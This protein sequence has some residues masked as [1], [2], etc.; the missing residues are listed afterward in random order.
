MEKFGTISEA[1]IDS[2]SKFAKQASDFLP[3]IVM[4]LVILIVGWLLAKLVSAGLRRGLK[5]IKFD[6]IL[7]KV[8]VD[9]LLSRIKP[10]LSPAKIV[11]KLVYWVL[12]L[13][14]VTAI[15][16]VLGWTMVTEGIAEFFAYL[17]T[18]L[19]ALVLFIVGI[20][21][22]DLVRTMVHTACNTIGISGASV[23]ANIV[24]YVLFI[25][26]AITAMNQAGIDTSLI[27][28]NVTIILGSILLAF[29][30]SYGIASRNIVSNMLSSYYGKGKFKEG[31]R[32]K[33][34][35]HEGLILQIDSISVTLD[36][37]NSRIVIP[38]K[39]LIEEEVEILKD[40]EP[41]DQKNDEISDGQ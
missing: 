6:E 32:I 41:I 8:Q 40:A 29:A 15:A 26:V 25:F 35:G 27:T 37:G 1:L 23:I 10:G 34:K 9:K 5:A 11:A 36:T 18:L 17:P 14:V 33:V 4:A 21:I 24:Y 38:S 3:M 28:S 31:Q 16:D 12:M 19:V 2:F 30:L 22:A 7:E 39:S 13:V 20:Y